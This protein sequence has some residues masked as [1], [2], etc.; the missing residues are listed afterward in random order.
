MRLHLLLLVCLG[1]IAACQR[2]L[3][4]SLPAEEDDIYLWDAAWSPDGK[5][6]AIGGDVDTVRILSAKS[7]RVVKRY[8]VGQTITK[9][10]WHPYEPILAVATQNSTH[11]VALINLTTE[12]ITHLPNILP[13]GGRGLGWNAT[14]ELLAFGDYEGDLSIY[15]RS[16]KLVRKLATGQKAIIGL[17]WHPV[18]NELVLV[19]E[20]ISRYDYDNDELLPGITP[21]EEEVLMLCVAWHPDGEFFVTGDYGDYEKNYPALL[22]YWDSNGNSLRSVEHSKAEYRNL[23]W[24]PDGKL[25][26]TASEAVRLWTYE[27]KLVRE[28]MAPTLLW[29][30]DWSPNGKQLITSGADGVVIL[31]DQELRQLVSSLDGTKRVE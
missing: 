8:P 15:N 22:Q 4:W 20:F 25:L 18:T 16:G 2:P 10:K 7:R 28:T 13:V 5:Y 11:G 1:L 3:N 17:C 24:S 14:G 23:R 19:G 6:I 27:G 29:G 12:T 21:R 9:V 30:I 31:W 26:A